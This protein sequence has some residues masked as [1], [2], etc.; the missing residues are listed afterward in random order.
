M[1]NISKREALGGPGLMQH[2]PQGRVA[3][4]T[5]AEGALRGEGVPQDPWCCTYTKPLGLFIL[6]SDCSTKRAPLH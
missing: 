6:L 4:D 3:M 2:S 1:V 5:R